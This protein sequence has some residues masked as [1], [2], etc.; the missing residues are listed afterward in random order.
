M[1]SETLDDY[2]LKICHSNHTCIPILFKYY[3]P[4]KC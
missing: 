2:R 1:Y 3:L 4:G